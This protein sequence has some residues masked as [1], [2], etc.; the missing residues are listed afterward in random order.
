MGIF[1]YGSREL[2]HLRA[3]DKKLG[4][5][6]DRIGPIEREVTLNLFIA[7]VSSVAS[8]QISARAAET[9]WRRMEERFSTITPASIAAASLDGLRG[10]GISARKAGYIRGIG[11]AVVNGSLDLDGLCDL[12]DE[13]V[14]S[15]LTTLKGVGAWTAEMILIFSMERPDVLSFGDLAIRRGMLRLYGGT[16]ISPEQFERYRRRYSPYGSVASLYLWELSHRPSE[17]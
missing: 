14:I 15:R 7:L 17:R 6:I 9:V 5:A 13:E 3:R 8:Q 10:C 1:R 4:R 16:S 12:P 11:E 2:D